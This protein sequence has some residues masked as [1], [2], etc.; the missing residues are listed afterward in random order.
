LI[1]QRD[2]AGYIPTDNDVYTHREKS[3]MR[4]RIFVEQYN[5][6]QQQQQLQ[7]QFMLGA[8]YN[9]EKEQALPFDI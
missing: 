7:Q 6:Q 3:A 4:E 9:R 2:Q 5:K 8:D 1:N